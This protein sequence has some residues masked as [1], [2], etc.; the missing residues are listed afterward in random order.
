MKMITTGMKQKERRN[1]CVRGTKSWRA[2]LLSA[3]LFC[4]VSEGAAA[5][6]GWTDGGVASV[7]N[8]TLWQGTLPLMMADNN[9]PSVTLTPNY[10]SGTVTASSSDPGTIRFFYTINGETPVVTLEDDEPSTGYDTYE[11]ING[12]IDV[13]DEATS[14]TV[15]AVR[16]DEVNN[17]LTL[18]Q[19]ESVTMTIE[20][21]ASPTASANWNSVSNHTI[22]VVDP[23]SDDAST[24]VRYDIESLPSSASSLVSG[25]TVAVTRYY[26]NYYFRVFG[27]NKFPSLGSLPLYTNRWNIPVIENYVPFTAATSTSEAVPASGRFVG[28]ADAYVYINYSHMSGD[29]LADPGPTT[30]DAVYAYADNPT[31]PEGFTAGAFKMVAANAPSAEGVTVFPSPVMTVTRNYSGYFVIQ[32]TD[33]EAHHYLCLDSNLLTPQVLTKEL[34]DRSSLW[35]LDAEYNLY[36][37]IGGT[38]YYLGYNPSTQA[39]SVTTT[40]GLANWFVDP[41]SHM[42]R[43]YNGLHLAYT[44]NGWRMSAEPTA[45]PVLFE[46]EKRVAPSG[47]FDE[48]TSFTL[49]PIQYDGRS[50]QWMAMADGDTPCSLSVTPHVTVTTYALPEHIH[51]SYIDAA[52]NA[53][54][55][56]FYERNN[57]SY[58]DHRFLPYRQES[59]TNSTIYDTNIAYTWHLTFDDAEQLKP[60]RDL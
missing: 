33:N 32:M 35:S 42:L 28:N 38:N 59:S 20:R 18:S 9:A 26:A 25:G 14:L 37:T 5:P 19:S 58:Q 47:H 50:P 1:C 13:E 6:S 29:T 43:D 31:I 40:A 10:L 21:Y 17:E 60:G 4:G 53:P 11:T 7:K 27:N 24:I 46:V 52:G 45:T 8:A 41:T 36:Q 54:D 39:V 15:I 55:F 49:D 30:Y 56:S 3:L 2:I 23:N 44:A 22:T 57:R 34:F 48:I 51:Y 12:I 16:L